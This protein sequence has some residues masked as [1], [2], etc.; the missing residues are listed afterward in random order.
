MNDQLD[1]AG[2]FKNNKP[3]DNFLNLRRSE[4]ISTVYH[5][6]YLG[7]VEGDMDYW[8][9]PPTGFR[10]DCDFI[11]GVFGEEFGLAIGVIVKSTGNNYMLL[12]K[13]ADKFPSTL[14]ECGVEPFVPYGEK[15]INDI[16][17]MVS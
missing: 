4:D 7:K 14:I 15:E 3:K 12:T 2:T 11:L 16:V 17:A 5:Q 9:E 10:H 8:C 13:N 6:E 1:F